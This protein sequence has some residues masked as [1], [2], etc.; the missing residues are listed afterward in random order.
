MTNI[1]KIIKLKEEKNILYSELLV[2]IQE[3]II[4]KSVDSVLK[5]PDLT[6]GN[7]FSLQHALVQSIELMNKIK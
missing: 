2:K 3:E 4:K 1:D 7:I 5:Q 6:G